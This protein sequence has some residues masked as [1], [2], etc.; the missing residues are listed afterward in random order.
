MRIVDIYA[1]AT[2]SLTTDP[3]ANDLADLIPDIVGGWEGI[4]VIFHGDHT[5]AIRLGNAAGT[6]YLP[7]PSAQFGEYS[8]LHRDKM[9]QNGLLFLSCA[10]GT[11]DCTVT[12]VQVAE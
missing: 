7:L 8:T 3:T 1:T 12:L 5:A 6:K 10:A 9:V 2:L 11:T 4:A